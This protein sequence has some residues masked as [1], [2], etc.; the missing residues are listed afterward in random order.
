MALAETVPVTLQDISP[1]L[2][3]GTHSSAASPNLFAWE[4]DLR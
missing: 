1:F 4:P 2:P 3:A